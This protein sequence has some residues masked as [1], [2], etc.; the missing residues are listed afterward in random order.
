MLFKRR[1][2]KCKKKEKKRIHFFYN[3]FLFQYAF[4]NEIKSLFKY[5]NEKKSWRLIKTYNLNANES[6]ILLCKACGGMLHM[7]LEL[8]SFFFFFLFSHA[9]VIIAIIIIALLV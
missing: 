1:K 9:F 8:F 6:A 2:K 4:V 3:S 7:G 5:G